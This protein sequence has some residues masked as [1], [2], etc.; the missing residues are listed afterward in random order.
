MSDEE[1]VQAVLCEA[2]MSDEVGEDEG[3]E[4]LDP[5]SPSSLRDAQQAMNSS[6]PLLCSYYTRAE[7]YCHCQ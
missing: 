7:K 5:P 4:E 1:I 6:H 2:D 3:E